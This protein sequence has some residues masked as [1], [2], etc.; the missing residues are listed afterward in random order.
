MR[1]QYSFKLVLLTML[2]VMSTVSFAQS[3]ISGKIV[4]ESEKE[5]IPGVAVF[6]KEHSVGAAT[7]FNG[8]FKF[9]TDLKGKQV[10]VVKYIGYKT[11]EKEIN[12]N[13]GE[14]KVGTV[15]LESSSIGLKEVNVVAS[16]A[17][18][19]ET[20]VAVS[21]IDAKAI[22]TK[23]GN[24]ELPEILNTTP[25]VYSTKGGGGFGD[26]RINIR[27]FDQ[28]NVGVLI[29]G[30][31]INDMENGWV[32]WS[33]WAGLGDAVSS[34]QVQRGLGASK[35]AINS[36]GGTMNII[37]KTIEAKKGGM[38]ELSTTSY[39]NRKAVIGLNT[40]LLEN[41]LAVS[42]VGS[43]T[44]GS[45]YI[46]GTYIDAWSYYLSVAKQLNENHRLQFTIIGAPQEHGQ[47]DNSQFSAQSYA[48]NE[49]YGVKHNPNWG[50]VRG[51]FLNERN[52][53]YHKP[54]IALNHYWNIS[55]KSFLATS[56][57]ISTG[58]GGGS[59]ILGR[60]TVKYGSGQNEFDQRNWDRAVVMNDS[61][62]TGSHL[63]MRNSVNNHFWTGVLSTLKTDLNDNLKLIAGV[64]VRY[65]EGEHYREV[66]DLLG[67]NYWADGVNPRA[68]V[69]DKIAYQNT[70]IVTYGGLFGQLE[71][72][73]G[74]F[75]AFVAATGS[76][77]MYGRKDPY[78]YARGRETKESADGVSITGYNGKIGA[79]YNI[80]AYHNVFVNAGYYERAP[81]I[82]FVYI[83]FSN[84]KNDNIKTEKITGLEGGYGF[85]NGFLSAKLNGYYTKWADRWLKG[86][87]GNSTIN[88]QGV[89][90]V[91]TGVELEM[92]ANVTSKLSLNG[93]ASLG[94]W[95]Y[96]KDAKVDIFDNNQQLVG[97]DTVV[98]KGLKVGDAAQSQF[99]IG[100]S[101]KVTKDITVGVD[102]LYNDNLYAK[103]N[104]ESRTDAN[105]REQSYRIPGYGLV[106]G[107][108]SYNFKLAGL[109]STFS[110]NGYNLLNKSYVI[111]GWD[112]AQKDS[113]GQRVHGRENFKGFWGWGRNFNFAVKVR[114]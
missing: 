47:R 92:K 38:M 89:E 40:G 94:N 2:L 48:D 44:T 78:N 26:S 58:R 19:R 15:N 43:R 72:T 83:N 46:D 103:F 51:R 20:P 28:R 98:T 113:N 62:T 91:H 27:G 96:T 61:S 23:L 109:V 21:T 90:Q 24:Q 99:M 32:Y 53:Y 42:F 13:G 11:L 33:N 34:I 82:D 66:R 56:A 114:F 31:P 77:T 57:Y 86:R 30:V 102:Y 105:D 93:F 35:L 29:N 63:I 111:E 74:K 73:A 3:V 5:P 65:Y 110:I 104:P 55:E 68:Q 36:V 79:N 100:A 18:D 50:Y 10:L 88:F 52:N 81:F 9:K 49:K 1:T 87:F 54:Q 17:I 76:T 12:L 4:G 95:E 60:G 106:N 45:G 8:E 22:E 6:I 84:T 59:G 97:T 39:G 101:L 70:G 14:V 67:G 107:Y 16:V 75:S 112:N 7:D 41:N 69:G 80:N 108:A 64:D 71:Y 85:R 25:G 37:T